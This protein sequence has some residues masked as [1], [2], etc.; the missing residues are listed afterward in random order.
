MRTFRVITYTNL[1]NA[2]YPMSII[3]KYNLKKKTTK[4]NVKLQIKRKLQIMY[5]IK[6]FIYRLK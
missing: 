6:E 3:P 1:K 4:G 5:M 2:L